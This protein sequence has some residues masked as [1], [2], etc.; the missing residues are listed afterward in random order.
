MR[1]ILKFVVLLAT[2]C[3]LLS[4]CGGD[5]KK[6]VFMEMV[7]LS[8][9]TFMMSSPPDEP[10]RM[11]AREGEGQFQVTISNAFSIGKYQVTQAQFE[12]VM[13]YNPSTFLVGD[14]APDRAANNVNWFEAV[15]FCNKLSEKEGL[16][17][18]YAITNITRE[19]N[20]II[21]ATVTQDLTKKGYR[22][23]TEAE[24]E[25]AYRAGTTTAFYTGE[26][27]TNQQA[28]F[29]G[30]FPT[31]EERRTTAVGSFEAN[32]WGL[33]DM[34]GNVWEWVWDVFADY[35]TWK[36]GDSPVIDH[37]GPEPG[38]DIPDRR[39]SRGG[40]F[41][42]ARYGL[43][44]AHRYFNNPDVLVGSPGFRVARNN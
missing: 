18:V 36:A 10:E 42:M 23:P 6:P 4:A 14:D 2:L 21:E 16:Q 26:T 29:S 37:I 22:L 39:V 34:A 12:E 41:G 32:P 40:G 13:G 33:Y 28:N 44:A 17:L 1:N 3:S 5:D 30:T 9:G 15:E 7:L 27:I 31:A 19:G 35:P 43:R 11:D 20:S 24:W 38:G 25:Y 8:S